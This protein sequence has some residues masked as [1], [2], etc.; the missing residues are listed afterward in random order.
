MRVSARL[1]SLSSWRSSRRR[2]MLGTKCGDDMSCCCLPIFSYSGNQIYLSIIGHTWCCSTAYVSAGR[3]TQVAICVRL[4]HICMV[5]KICGSLAS[6]SS[7]KRPV[8]C[9]RVSKVCTPC[10]RKG[11]LTITYPALRPIVK[12]GR[13]IMDFGSVRGRFF[14]YFLWKRRGRFVIRAMMVTMI[15]IAIAQC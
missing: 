7:H 1:V 10:N 8:P 12:H 3:Q 6:S 5:A 9:T 14:F 2:L 11:H 15:L 13:A 4:D